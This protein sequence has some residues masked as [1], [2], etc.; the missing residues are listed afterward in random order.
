MVVDSRVVRTLAAATPKVF[1]V[2]YTAL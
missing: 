1:C 2:C